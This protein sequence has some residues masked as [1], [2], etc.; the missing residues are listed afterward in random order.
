M[1]SNKMMELRQLTTK[2][3]MWDTCPTLPIG[4][5]IRLSNL[6]TEIAETAAA[7]E[8]TTIDDEV[9]DHLIK[10]GG[11]SYNWLIKN[12]PFLDWM[13]EKASEME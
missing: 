8:I 9:L 7:N 3:L 5:M 2:L 12:H 1:S 6:V 11:D 4:L 10:K 13:K